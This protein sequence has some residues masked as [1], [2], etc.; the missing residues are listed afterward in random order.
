MWLH[1]RF[2]LHQGFEISKYARK[3]SQNT[4]WPGAGQIHPNIAKYTRKQK[5][6]I[7]SYT[8]ECASF[9]SQT[10]YSSGT[11]AFENWTPPPPRGGAK[12]PKARQSKRKK[13]DAA[14]AEKLQL[15][16][17]AATEGQSLEELLKRYDQSGDGNLDAKELK[18]LIRDDLKVPA[19]VVSNAEIESLVA[20]LHR[21]TL[22][23][24]SA[25]L[26][27]VGDLVDRE[28]AAAVVVERGDER[29]DLGVRPCV[30]SAV[31]CFVF[32]GCH[33]RAP[34]TA[35]RTGARGAWRGGGHRQP[36]AWASSK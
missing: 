25:A 5:R 17:K 15:K 28:L 10:Q 19:S 31:L 13:I 35:K 14:T 22:D 24:I 4:A 36:P 18:Q 32:G 9:V 11:A 2:H 29:F 21:Q 6:C 30:W 1:K 7:S 12:A 27:E 20:A 23:A 34:P 16:L 8:F 33:A 26:D 3:Y